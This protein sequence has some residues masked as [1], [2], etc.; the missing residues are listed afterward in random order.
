MTATKTMP[1]PPKMEPRPV[2]GVPSIDEA[3]DKAYGPTYLR[4]ERAGEKPIE[5][6]AWLKRDGPTTFTIDSGFGKFEFQVP[7]SRATEMVNLAARRFAE[8]QREALEMTDDEVKSY[9]NNA[10]G[11]IGLIEALL[12]VPEDYRIDRSCAGSAKGSPFPPLSRLQGNVDVATKMEAFDALPQSLV[13][14]F[15]R[16]IELM[17]VPALVWEQ[18]TGTGAQRDPS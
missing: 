13:F 7:G 1:R 8:S 4:P 11:A 18:T 12:A 17:R 2:G 3:Y 16:A 9:A 6:P 14:Q 15:L 10:S 5:V